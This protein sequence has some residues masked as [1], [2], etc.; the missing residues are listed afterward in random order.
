MSKFINTIKAFLASIVAAIK[1][2]FVKPTTT[3]VST[4]PVTTVPVVSA[5]VPVTPSPAPSVPSPTPSPTPVE[6]Q[7]SV[8]NYPMGNTVTAFGNPVVQEV[9]VGLYTVFLVKAPSYPAQVTLVDV[10][11]APPSVTTYT[12]KIDGTLVV[13]THKAIVSG[14]DGHVVTEDVQVFIQPDKSG[15]IGVQ[16]NPA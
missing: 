11:G 4:P 3:T 13:P 10:I 6:T 9:K 8:P 7:P 5:P 1:K 14:H 2:F 16:I 12:A 15:Y